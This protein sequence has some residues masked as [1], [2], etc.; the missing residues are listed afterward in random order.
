MSVHFC[1]DG[2]TNETVFR[3]IFFV[4]Q[5]SIHRAVSNLCQTSAGSP[6]LAE[7][8][9]PLFAPVNLLIM[10]PRP[11]IEIPAQEISLQKYMERVER[12]PQPDRLIKICTDARFLE[13]FEVGQYFMTKHT[14][15]FLQFAEP[16]ACQEMK[17]HLTRKVGFEGT[18]K[19][20]PCWKS[21]PVT[22]KV[23]MEWKLQWNM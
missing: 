13:T 21:Q 8:S 10:K 7:Q 1:A 23:S 12:L 15:E 16:V 22:F 18:P 20:D 9:D 17:N 5:L 6:V 14:D 11:S 2:D 19:L 4:N 3:T